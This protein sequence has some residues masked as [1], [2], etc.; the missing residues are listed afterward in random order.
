MNGGTSLRSDAVRLAGRGFTL[1][2]EICYGTAGSQPAAGA[3]LPPH[4]P[5][6]VAP[7]FDGF[8]L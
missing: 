3:A 7:F 8:A 5:R 4:S 1:R 2:L 6:W